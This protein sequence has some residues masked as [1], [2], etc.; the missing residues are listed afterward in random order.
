MTVA[1]EVI[2]HV[3]ARAAILTGHAIALIT[4]D[5]R[6]TAV[7]G[8]VAVEAVTSGKSWAYVYALCTVEIAFMIPE[9]TRIYCL[10]TVLSCPSSCT[11]TRP[12][13]YAGATIGTI[14][15]RLGCTFVDVLVTVICSPAGHAC[16]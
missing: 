6:D 2:E 14:V 10:V 1:A 16:A 15:A 7:R 3:Q 5:A 11:H 12:I 13:I 4:F 8:H 9:A